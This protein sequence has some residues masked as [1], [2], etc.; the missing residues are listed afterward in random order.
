MASNNRPI[1]LL[2]CLSKIFDKVALNQY[3][4]HL[5]K[6]QSSNRKNHSTKTLN[7]AV[8]DMLLEAMDNEQLSIVVFS[9]MS[10]AFNSIC[11]DMPLQ[12]IF[13]CIS[14]SA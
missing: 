4:E 6:H 7:I 1:S 13:R 8:T 2:S 12:I 5:T 14:G 9:G 11:H 10:K 3:T